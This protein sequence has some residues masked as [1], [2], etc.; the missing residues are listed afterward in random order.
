MSHYITTTPHTQW[1]L[2]WYTYTLSVHYSHFI[3]SLCWTVLRC[4]SCAVSILV[5][6]INI[7][8]SGTHDAWVVYP[9]FCAPDPVC[10]LFSSKLR[11][12]T[13]LPSTNYF[14]KEGRGVWG[15]ACRQT[16]PGWL[17]LSINILKATIVHFSR[18]FI[19]HP[20]RLNRQ[21]EG[22]GEK[23]GT[24]V[25]GGEDESE[26]MEWGRKVEDQ[27]KVGDDTE[28]NNKERNERRERETAEGE[29]EM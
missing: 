2:H 3:H 23:G 1:E 5:I 20:Q 15:R 4:I 27:E 8:S 17:F 19:R 21:S 25:Q 18:D 13:V 6:I 14:F 16:Q 22:E 7:G 10:L 12:F 26:G 11:A 24:R 29:K 9:W 28:K